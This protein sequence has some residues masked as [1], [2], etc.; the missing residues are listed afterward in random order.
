MP[1]KWT[2]EQKAKACEEILAKVQK[3]LGLK[4]ACDGD[5]WLPNES[6]FRF[7]C[8]SDP[9][10]SARY[11][12]AREDRADV[13]FEEMIDIA[14][15]ASNDWMERQG[16]KSAGWVLNGDH[17]QRS[18]LMIDTRKWM[19]AK[20]QPKKYGEKLDLNHGGA[21][22]ITISGDDADL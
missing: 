3:G 22:Q 10:L 4:T 8:D 7:W 15:N 6:T 1:I 11:A 20:M 17:V 9:D 13:I 12:R 14:D 18:K 5:D 2:D 16:E 19:L 21:L